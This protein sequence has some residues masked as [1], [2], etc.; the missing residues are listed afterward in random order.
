MYDSIYFLVYFF[1]GAGEDLCS[2]FGDGV[3]LGVRLD[4]IRLFR[5]LIF[6]V[7]VIGIARRELDLFGVIGGFLVFVIGLYKVIFV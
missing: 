1:S 6:V 2:R 4:G 5:R 7:W 3:D